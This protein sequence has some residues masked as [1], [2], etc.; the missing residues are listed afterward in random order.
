MTT[1]VR[2]KVFVAAL[3]AAAGVSGTPRDSRSAAIRV[4]AISVDSI[5]ASICRRIV[6][7]KNAP[8]TASARIDADSAAKKNLV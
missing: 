1:S 2:T 3:S 7:A 4:S 8:A 6:V 5:R